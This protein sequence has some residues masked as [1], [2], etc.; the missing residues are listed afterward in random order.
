MCSHIS[1][2]L[3]CS[4]RQRHIQTDWISGHPLDNS[5]YLEAFQREHSNISV[6]ACSNDPVF[7]SGSTRPKS[8]HVVY[9]VRVKTQDHV[10][11]YLLDLML[12]MTHNV[13]KGSM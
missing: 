1:G 8:H 7:R 10:W 4:I 6:V 9:F 5:L 13:V 2:L 3:V 12:V 11:V